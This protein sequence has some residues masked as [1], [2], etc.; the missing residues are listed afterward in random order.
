[1]INDIYCEY[2]Y[3]SHDTIGVLKSNCTINKSQCKDCDKYEH[4]TTPNYALELLIYLGNKNN[5]INRS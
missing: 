5:K 2:Y 4:R 3:I 1:M